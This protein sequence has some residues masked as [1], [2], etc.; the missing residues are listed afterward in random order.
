M[1]QQ[2]G[3]NDIIQ[4]LEKTAASAVPES[5]Y[6]QQIDRWNRYQAILDQV[7]KIL[8]TVPYA[9]LRRN[10][11]TSVRN[12]EFYALPLNF[13]L[14]LTAILAFMLGM[15]ALNRGYID[16]S[17]TDTLFAVSGGILAYLTYYNLSR[18]GVIKPKMISL[19]CKPEISIDEM[20]YAREIIK[21]IPERKIDPLVRLPALEM[22]IPRSWI[23]Q[24]AMLDVMEKVSRVNLGNEKQI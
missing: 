2:D 19:S 13:G 16:A 22:E 6:Q 21:E 9:N 8:E 11:R 24:Q 17:T 18:L 7:Q 20:R 12:Y 5:D 14:G 3:I 23:S 10:I 4:T 15:V 1:G